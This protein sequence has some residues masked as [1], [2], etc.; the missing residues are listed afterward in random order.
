M[1]ITLRQIEIFLNV[2]S[3]GH[4]TSVSKDMGLSQSA[5]SMSIKELELTLGKQLFDRISKRLILNEVGRSFYDEI[6]P[7][8][9][10]VIDVQNEFQFSANKGVIRVGASTTIVDYMMPTIICSYMNEYPDVKIS[11]KEGNT[12]D[13]IEMIK[14]GQIDIGFVE[15]SVN[16]S[17]LIK[18][19]VGV[20]ELVVVSSTDKFSTPSSMSDLCN[21]KW[22]LREKGSG[23]REMFL[24]YIKDTCSNLNIFLELGH[25]ESIKNVLKGSDTLACISQIAVEKDIKDGSLF[26]A[27]I[28]KFEC[29]RDLYMI[30]HRD[31]LRS[32]LFDKFTFFAKKM[33]KTILDSKQ[34]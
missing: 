10:K 14:D 28:K 20:D 2:V 18:E 9:K 1:N 5:I 15:G 31:K 3:V 27:N 26:K 30:H 12:K 24:E 25:T 13:I 6:K 21:L 7:L 32:E 4:L 34:N 16:D 8:Y 17:E 23:T 29:K 33:I 22:V 19:I 11:L